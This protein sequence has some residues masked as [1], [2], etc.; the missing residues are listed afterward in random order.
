M[1]IPAIDLSSESSA[2]AGPAMVNI[3]VADIFKG[4]LESWNHSKSGKKFA[5]M[6]WAK[7]TRTRVYHNRIKDGSGVGD[8]NGSLTWTLLQD[9]RKSG[10][11]RAM[12]SGREL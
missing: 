8:A 12:E 10:C 1:A 5:E 2:K 3:K 9:A 4:V 6:L 11:R 7:N